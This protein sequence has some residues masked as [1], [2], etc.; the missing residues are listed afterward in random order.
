MST[1][2]IFAGLLLALYFACA[3]RATPAQRDLDERRELTASGGALALIV[4]AFDASRGGSYSLSNGANLSLIRSGITNAFCTTMV[5]TE[6]LNDAFLASIDA[7]I[8]L[9]PKDGWVGIVPLSAQ[10]QE[11]LLG[12][13]LEGGGALLFGDHRD[14]EAASDSFFNPFGIDITGTIS[15]DRAATVTNQ[16]SPVTNGAYGTINGFNGSWVGWFNN[17]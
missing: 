5:E 4:G 1:K 9:S 6:V 15:G 13:V 3:S 8:L 7:L 2:R 16:D 12:F 11:S 14:F 10:E 17:L